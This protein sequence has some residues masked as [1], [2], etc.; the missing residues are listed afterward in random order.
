MKKVLVF[1][2]SHL[3]NSRIFDSNYNIVK[4]V[5]I[6]DVAKK[7]G[8]G[9]STVSY[10]LNKTGL[11]KVGL[12]TQERIRAAAAELHYTPNIAGK[13]LKKGV[14]YTVGVLFPNIRGTFAFNILAGLEDELNLAGYS[15]LLCRYCDEE[16]FESKCQLLC[17]KQIDGVIILNVHDNHIDVIRK[18]D[19]VHPVTFLARKQTIPE[20]PAVCVDGYQIYHLAIRHFIEQGHRKIVV[21]SGT[22]ASNIQGADDAIGNSGAELFFTPLEICSGQALLDW[23]LTLKERPTAFLAFSDAFAFEFIGY[24][25]D[26]GFR[27]PDDFSIIGVDGDEFGALIRPALTTIQQPSIAQGATAAKQLLSKIREGQADN[28]VMQPQLLVRQSVKK[29]S[30][31]GRH[32]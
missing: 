16:D 17:G 2:Y 19:Q 7:A 12:K 18:L 1:K 31:G 30:T 27:I 13:A 22:N 28:I 11:N 25:I 10:V 29:I 32:D 15:M 20:I 24:A 4:M 5:T 3:D 6:S 23:G 14:T 8:V 26:C 21:Q 9:I